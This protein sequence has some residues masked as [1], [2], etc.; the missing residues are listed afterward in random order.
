MEIDLHDVIVQLLFSNMNFVTS[1][2][3]AQCRTG[4]VVVVVVVF[5]FCIDRTSKVF[6]VEWLEGEIKLHTETRGKGERREE[7]KKMNGYVEDVLRSTRWSTTN[8]RD[9]SFIILIR[10]EGREERRKS[11]DNQRAIVALAEDI[12]RLIMY[13]NYKQAVI[14]IDDWLHLTII[15]ICRSVRWIQVYIF[16]MLF[17]FFP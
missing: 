5:F 3:L 13:E 7:R 1:I 10:H 8:R 2:V 6:V 17:L 4:I 14:L 11:E 12:Q 15:E 16:R 9:V